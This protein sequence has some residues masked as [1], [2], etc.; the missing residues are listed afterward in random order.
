MLLVL[1]S[2]GGG[3]GTSYRDVALGVVLV[4]L[5]QEAPQGAPLPPAGAPPRT[6]LFAA[7]KRA[8]GVLCYLQRRELVQIAAEMF[9]RSPDPAFVIMTG[10]DCFGGPVVKGACVDQGICAHAEAV[11]SLRGHLRRNQ[12][13]FVRGGRKRADARL[14]RGCCRRPLVG[15]VPPAPSR[16]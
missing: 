2:Q 1:Q 4:A 6:L 13:G 10:V 3:L 15:S 11:R 16:Y 9:R 14:R 12:N 5:P 8:D 7:Q